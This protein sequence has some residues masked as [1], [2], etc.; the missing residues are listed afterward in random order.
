[1]SLRIIYFQK[2]QNVN[3]TKKYNKI[4]KNEWYQCHSRKYWHLCVAK[5]DRIR[6]DDP[7]WTFSHFL[8]CCDVIQHLRLQDVRNNLKE[9]WICR[10]FLLLFVYLLCMIT[11]IPL[12]L[13]NSHSSQI[14]FT[15]F[16]QR[17]P[18]QYSTTVAA[19]KNTFS[20]ASGALVW[21]LSM[22]TLEKYFW[23]FS[24]Y[25]LSY[26]FRKCVIQTFATFRHKVLETCCYASC[27]RCIC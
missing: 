10:W 18:L 4:L 7:L 16:A 12:A 13:S 8:H 21:N 6:I 2:Y 9:Y 3:K 1:M 26:D 5:F 22:S 19:F 14:M 17:K 27:I 11:R 15:K 23:S 24:D 20:P 25:P